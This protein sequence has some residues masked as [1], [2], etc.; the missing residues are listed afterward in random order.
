MKYYKCLCNTNLH[1]ADLMELEGCS[2]EELKERLGEL[3]GGFCQF[4]NDSKF[5][6]GFRQYES[7]AKGNQVFSWTKN[8]HDWHFT[9]TIICCDYEDEIN[10]DFE[11]FFEMSTTDYVAIR[12]TMEQFKA[13]C[14]Q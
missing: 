10:A 7:A 12:A 3:I 4:Y 9:A 8:G 14:T 5:G 1:T 11:P 6:R 2:N 13:Q